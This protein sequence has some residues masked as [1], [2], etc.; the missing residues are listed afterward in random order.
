M[1]AAERPAVCPCAAWTGRTP[2][3]PSVR[4]TPQIHT[5]SP[6]DRAW[7][8]NA[9]SLL[10]FGETAEATTAPARHTG[11]SKATLRQAACEAPGQG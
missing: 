3:A 8:G 7:C 4:R 9:C 5:L 11:L 6:E 1:A 2:R 10:S